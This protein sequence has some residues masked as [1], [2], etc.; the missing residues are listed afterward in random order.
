M[1]RANA[2]HGRKSRPNECSISTVLGSPRGSQIAAP[3]NMAARTSRQTQRRAA[4]TGQP[5]SI[6]AVGT[7]PFILVLW[8]SERLHSSTFPVQATLQPTVSAGPDDEISRAC[9][10]TVGIHIR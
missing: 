10:P 5:G 7:R 4:R 6:A 9:H 8:Q 3:D 1:V 2:L